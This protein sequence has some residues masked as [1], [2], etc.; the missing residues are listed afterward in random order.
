[1]DCVAQCDFRSS[2]I[3]PILVSFWAAH[4]CPAKYIGDY[5]DMS[6]NRL[7]ARLR[8]PAF[9]VTN[10]EGSCSL[11]GC[12]MCVWSN[13]SLPHATSPDSFGSSALCVIGSNSNESTMDSQ[14]A[15]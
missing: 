4:S 8:D 7:R 5:T 1:M 2:D 11:S 10:D 12:H 9:I 6:K 13:A 3:P 15:I 14:A